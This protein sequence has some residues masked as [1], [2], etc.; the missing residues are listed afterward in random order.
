MCRT[1]RCRSSDKHH[2]DEMQSSFYCACYTDGSDIGKP[3]S[4]QVFCGLHPLWNRHASKT[5]TVQKTQCEARLALNIHLL[6]KAMASAC[7]A[8][9]STLPGHP[10]VSPL[11]R[12]CPA[13]RPRPAILA[14]SVI[15]CLK[16]VAPLTHRIQL[17]KIK[18]NIK[19]GFDSIRRQ[20][21]CQPP[22]PAAESLASNR[23]RHPLP[24]RALVPLAK[25]FLKFFCLEHQAIPAT[26]KKSLL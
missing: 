15:F 2:Q 20:M 7:L 16:G 24:L 8:C 22:H 5:L 23:F 25:N 26:M 10:M 17:S 9:L 13:F 1:L 4:L 19:V 14:H 6:S 11:S 21:F 18:S 3:K 12:S